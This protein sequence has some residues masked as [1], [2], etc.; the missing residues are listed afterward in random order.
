MN[1]AKPDAEVELSAQ[2]LMEL[3]APREHN[4]GK[5]KAPVSVSPP[6][7]RANALAPR[8]ISILGLSLSFVLLAAAVGVAYLATAPSSHTEQNARL[9]QSQL[10]AAAPANA[11]EPVRFTNPF[12]AKEVFEFA[13]GT[14]EAEARDAVAEILMERAMERQRKYDAR[15]S[16]NH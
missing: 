16:S 5:R 9:P 7:A 2:D 4:E 8:R 6:R 13:P 10:P 12:D 11:G 3:A 14:S 1:E 15:V